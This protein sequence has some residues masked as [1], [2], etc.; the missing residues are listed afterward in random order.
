VL[1]VVDVPANEAREGDVSSTCTHQGCRVFQ[2]DLARTGHFSAA[3]SP[4]ERPR[5]AVDEVLLAM[6]ANRRINDLRLAET[7]CTSS[8]TAASRVSRAARFMGRAVG[9]ISWISW[10]ASTKPGVQCLRCTP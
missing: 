4:R 9:A 5:F 2:L 8:V 1:K 3:G 10:D 6:E 7:A